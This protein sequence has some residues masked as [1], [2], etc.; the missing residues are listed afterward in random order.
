MI[1]PDTF[2]RIQSLYAQLLVTANQA[3]ATANCSI[4]IGRITGDLNSNCIINIKNVCRNQGDNLA[5]LDVAVS[6]VLS[7]LQGVNT[8]ALMTLYNSLRQDCIAQASVSQ[9]ITVQ[10]LDLG[11][12]RP[13]F[14]TQ[15]NFTNSGEAVSNCLATSLLRL[16]QTE[17]VVQESTFIQSLQDN[18]PYIAL[19]LVGLG[20]IAIALIVLG[21]KKVTI[22]WRRT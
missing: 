22:V 11:T 12:C 19:T 20:V 6:T 16:T 15:F 21:R 4:A 5:I 9:N 8:S 10:D 17:S 13:R 7:I 14:E 18:F 1:T 3:S 2:N